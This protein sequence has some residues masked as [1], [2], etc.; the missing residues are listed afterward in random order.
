MGLWVGPSLWCRL[1]HL[2][3]LDRLPLNFVQTGR[4]PSIPPVP[5]WG[6]FLSCF[7]S[8]PDKVWRIVDTDFIRSLLFTHAKRSRGFSAQRRSQQPQVLHTIQA[9]GGG[10]GC[11]KCE[12]TPQWKSQDFLVGSYLHKLSWHLCLSL[13]LWFFTGRYWFCFSFLCLSR[14]RS[15]TNPGHLC[16]HVHLLRRKCV[17]SA[18]SRE[19]LKAAWDLQGRQRSNRDCY[20]PATTRLSLWFVFV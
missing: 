15:I 19:S 5:E 6:W 7:Q 8:S 11:R 18:E 4:F 9:R 2:N 3:K 12:L 1:N 14:V 20:C 10:A 17:E 16:S 13:C